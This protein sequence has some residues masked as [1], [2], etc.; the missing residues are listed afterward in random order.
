MRGLVILLLIG[1]VAWF[2]MRY[3]HVPPAE[4]AKWRKLALLYGGLGVLLLLVLTNRVTPLL[5]LFGAVTPWIH[6]A[7]LAKNMID[8]FRTQGAAAADQVSRLQ[9]RFLKVEIDP[10]TGAMHAVVTEGEHTGEVLADLSEEQLIAL[11]QHVRTQDEAS[12]QLL[13]AWM[14]REIGPRWRHS[15]GVNQGGNTD[16][17]SRNATMSI[18]DAYAVLGLAEGCSRDDIVGAHRKLIGR[19]HPDK[20]GGDW[21]AAKVNEAKAVLLERIS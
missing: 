13:Q 18:S 4:Q 19:V 17:P 12:A 6:R 15:A 10:T 7:I 1:V 16:S 21:L 11:W 14:D 9:T 20:G 3:R 5:G 8:R 2:F